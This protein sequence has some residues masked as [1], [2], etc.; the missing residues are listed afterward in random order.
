MMSAATARNLRIADEDD[1]LVGLY[2]ARKRLPSRLLFDA[3]GVDLFAKVRALASYY[4][5]RIE[6]ALAAQHAAAIAHQAGANARVIEIGCGDP[7]ITLALLRALDRP[8]SYVPVELAG[9]VLRRT[10]LLVRE[11]IAGLD[12]QP[13]LADH[14]E[15]FELPAPQHAYGKTLILAPSG[16]L[17]TLEPGEARAVLARLGR[18]AGPDRL[19]LLGADGTRDPE[20]LARA[21]GDPQGPI[22]AFDRNVLAHLNRTRGATFDLDAF[23]H[24]AVWN[25]EA[26]CLELHLVSTRPQ[27]VRVG[28]AAIALDAGESILTERNYKHAPPAMQALLAAGGWRPRQVFTSSELPYRWWLCESSGDAQDRLQPARRGSRGVR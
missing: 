13:V 23:E 3:T 9:D 19:L 27:R 25:A 2:A 1:V 20:A 18:L 4:P 12:V 28:A 14:T 5:A 21:Y 11:A 8:N 6:A 26:S 7:R 17:D 15:A 22:A 10:T 16:M 24:R